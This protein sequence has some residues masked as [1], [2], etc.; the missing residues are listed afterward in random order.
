M[1]EELMEDQG[2]FDEYQMEEEETIDT[3]LLNP[4]ALDVVNGSARLAFLRDLSQGLYKG[5]MV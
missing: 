4:V 1:N 2:I 3:S 5:G